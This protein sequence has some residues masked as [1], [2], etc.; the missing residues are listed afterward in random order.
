MQQQFAPLQETP[1]VNLQVAPLENP[2]DIE[3]GMEQEEIADAET[4]TEI[5]VARQTLA[6]LLV[7]SERKIRSRRIKFWGSFAFVEVINLLALFPLIVFGYEILGEIR[8]PLIELV[9][10]SM[11]V[12]L[13]ITLRVLFMPVDFGAEELVE[14]GGIRAIPVL[15]GALNS[16]IAPRLRKTLYSM[17]ATLLPQLKATDANLL[18]ARHRSMLNNLL[19]IETWPGSGLNVGN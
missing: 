12:A 14:A 9:V 16:G 19:R 7:K 6:D 18:T 1:P 5:L 8:L 10:A 13:I 11:L 15:L 4:E 2:S 3:E 17:L